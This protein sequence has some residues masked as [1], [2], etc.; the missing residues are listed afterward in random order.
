MANTAYSNPHP[1][2]DTIARRRYAT[3]RYSSDELGVRSKY[4]L[5]IRASTHFFIMGILGVNRALAWLITCVKQK[6]VWTSLV[7]TGLSRFC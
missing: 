6:Q 3:Y 2:L 4:C 5:S 7:M 1:C